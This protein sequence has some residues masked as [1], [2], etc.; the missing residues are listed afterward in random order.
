MWGAPPNKRLKLPAHVDKEEKPS[1]APLLR[2]SPLGGAS[3]CRGHLCR[4][5]LRSSGSRS[6]R[7]L[8]LSLRELL[9]RRASRVDRSSACTHPLAAFS[10]RDRKSTRLNSSH[11]C[12]SYA[13]FCL[14][15]K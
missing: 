13:V 10:L 4:Y 15:K 11:R 8:S 6:L 1:V 14:K 3:K 2:R 9:V 7:S 5:I 12:I